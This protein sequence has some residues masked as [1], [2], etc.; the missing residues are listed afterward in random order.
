MR[1]IARTLATRSPPMG[2]RGVVRGRMEVRSAGS[3]WKRASY[4]RQAALS[5]SQAAEE[6]QR[7]GPRTPG[8]RQPLRT[9]KGSA[10]C[11]S[12]HGLKPGHVG[13]SLASCCGRALRLS[14]GAASC[15]ARRGVLGGG[16][17]GPPPP[18]QPRLAEGDGPGAPARAEA[19]P[20]S[21]QAGGS[22]RMRRASASWSGR[23]A[24]AHLGD[25]P[26]RRGLP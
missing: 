20:R 1:R 15:E 5:A 4:H 11:T 19:R 7:T 23:D 22:R 9:S 14:V 17:G 18:T 10:G 12:S 26:A 21:S 3:T 8:A 24:S 6:W 13:N 25:I 2:R 16:P